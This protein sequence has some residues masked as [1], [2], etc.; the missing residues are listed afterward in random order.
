MRGKTNSRYL[1]KVPKISKTHLKYI[2]LLLP[3][4]SINLMYIMLKCIIL[5]KVTDIMYFLYN[6]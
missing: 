1:K 3:F 6:R 5:I 4:L 2:V